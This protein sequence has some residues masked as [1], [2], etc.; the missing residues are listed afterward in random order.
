MPT[1]IAHMLICNKAVKVLRG[2]GGE[3]QQFIDILDSESYK[4]YWNLGA[5]CPD[6]FFQLSLPPGGVK[7]CREVMDSCFRRNDILRGSLN[8]GDFLFFEDG[9]PE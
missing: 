8:Y 3:Y 9:D 4:P 7:L 1:N 2:E 5:V 6:L